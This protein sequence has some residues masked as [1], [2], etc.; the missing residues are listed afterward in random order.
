MANLNMEGAIGH[1]NKVLA[2]EPNNLEAM[3]KKALSINALK[4]PTEECFTLI[5]K[6]LSLN[7]NSSELLDGRAALLVSQKKYWNALTD[8]KTSINLNEKNMIAYWT[9]ANAHRG[10]EQ[11]QMALLEFDKVLEFLGDEPDIHLYRGDS[12]HVLESQDAFDWVDRLPKIDEYH[13]RKNIFLAIYEYRRHNFVQALEL[14]QGV[15]IAFRLDC[16]DLWSI[17]GDCHLGNKNFDSAIESYLK[18]TEKINDPK[19]IKALIYAYKNKGN[20]EEAKKWTEKL[21]TPSPEKSEVDYL[22]VVDAIMK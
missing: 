2:E 12:L 19:T 20:T 7:P 22:R 1:F 5:N 16:I 4:G 3:Y 15:K 6:A 17:R 18:V 8:L 14:L 9:K 13:P 21:K 11:H 10:L